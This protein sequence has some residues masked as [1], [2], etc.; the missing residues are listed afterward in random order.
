[1]S[2][3][4]LHGKHGSLFIMKHFW[5]GHWQFWLTLLKVTTVLS[6]WSSFPLVPQSLSKLM[7][8]TTPWF[9]SRSCPAVTPSE[10]PGR[11]IK[12]Q[13]GSSI[14]PQA[15]EGFW[16]RNGWSLTML[17]DAKLT[18][19]EHAGTSYSHLITITAQGESSK[20]K[21]FYSLLQKENYSCH[22]F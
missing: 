6:T 20:Y 3:D 14:S 15:Q 1:M 11:M 9:L 18:A 13:R 2:I 12:H 22:L 5:D 7:T 16:C 21:T 10:S 8:L 19:L 17:P 4:V